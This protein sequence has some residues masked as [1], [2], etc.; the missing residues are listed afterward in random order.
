MRMPF[1]PILA[2]VIAAAV[3]PVGAT[4]GHYKVKDLKAISGPSP[5]AAGCPGALFDETHIAG[6]EIEPFVTVNPRNPSNIIATWQQDLGFASRSDLIG[7]S[8]NGGKTWTRVTIPG[9]TRCTGGSYDAASD[10]WVSAGPDG[11]VYFTGLPASLASELP[12]IALVAR[13]RHRVRDGT[14]PRTALGSRANGREDLNSGLR[15]NGEDPASMGRLLPRAHHTGDLLPLL[16]LP[17]EPR[18]E[19][20]RRR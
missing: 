17:G 15:R 13:S 14:R 11:T 16:V 3:V 1:L 2:V 7:T 4:A 12:A 9:L 5:F 10:P 6:A 18:A 20:L 8:R 19:G